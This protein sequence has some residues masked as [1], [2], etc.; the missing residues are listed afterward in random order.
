MGGM[1]R[2]FKLS[3]SLQRGGACCQRDS[4]TCCCLLAG[5]YAKML[6]IHD[7]VMS[8]VLIRTE[9]EK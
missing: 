3:L 9:D 1:E 6:N 8:Q 5:P 4:G 7:N 2:G